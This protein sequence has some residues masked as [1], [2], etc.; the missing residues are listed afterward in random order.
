MLFSALP[1]ALQERLRADAPSREYASSQIIAQRGDEAKGFWLIEKGSVS[2]GQFFPDGEFR[3]VA[4]IGPGDS[5]GELAM[6]ASRPRVVDAIARTRSEVRHIRAA[7]FEALLEEHPAAS[8]A[9]LGTLSQQLQETLNIV[10]GIRR[11]SAGARVAGLLA[12]MSEGSPLPARIAMSQQEL[13]DLLGLTRA[14]V[15]AALRGQEKLG[16]LRRA[17]GSIEVLDRDGLAISAIA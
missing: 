17:Y 2:I 4:V 14:T 13:A 8:R 15:N 9:L 10:A 12:T 11:G 5:W 3:G 16:L 7:L 1:T 6:F